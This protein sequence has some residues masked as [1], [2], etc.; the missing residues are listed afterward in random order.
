MKKIITILLTLVIIL[1]VAACGNESDNSVDTK[2]VAEETDVTEDKDLASTEDTDTDAL[3]DKDV[4]STEETDGASA[5]KNK[6]ITVILMA[7][8]SDYWHMVE[9]G[10][11]IAGEETGYNVSVIGPNSESDAVAQSNMIQDAAN[12]NVGAIVLAANEPQVQISPVQYAKDAGIP[13]ILIDAFLETDDDTVYDSFIGTD[14]YEAGYAA[15]EYLSEKLEEGSKVAIIRGLV[16]QPT[17][18]VRTNGAVDAFEE[19]GMEVVAIQP[20]DSDRGKALNVMQNILQNH[21]D[22]GAVYCT[23][24]EMALGAHEAI[25]SMNL[26]ALTMGFDGSFGALDSIEAGE[27]TASLAQKPIDEGYLGVMAAID[28]IEGREVEKNVANGFVIVDANNVENFRNEI[29]EQMEKA[30]S[31]KK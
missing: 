31:Y 13:V 26:D 6:D 16:A 2:E 25:K 24:D 27:L 3:E 18:D 17:H 22:I 9:A 23:N 29:N 15:G 11:L 4:P 1:T 19:A 20:A 14:N 28:V 21:P 30:E 8:N 5:D 7:L 10:A 12:N